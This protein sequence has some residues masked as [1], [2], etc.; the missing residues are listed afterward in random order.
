MWISKIKENK[1]GEIIVYRYRYDKQGN[2]VETASYDKKDK[3]IDIYGGILPIILTF[4]KTSSTNTIEEKEYINSISKLYETK[5]IHC[6]D[7]AKEFAENQELFK[8]YKN[9]FFN[10][11]LNFCQ[12]FKIPIKTSLS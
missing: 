10:Q 2:N 1:N 7:L 8:N 9:N 12:E 11:S 5:Q 3:L 4:T 6:I